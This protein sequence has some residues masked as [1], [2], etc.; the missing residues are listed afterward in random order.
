MATAYCE[1]MCSCA[2]NLTAHI[3]RWLIHF[4]YFTK[5]WW[6]L[7]LPTSKFNIIICLAKSFQSH[8]GILQTCCNILHICRMC[9]V[10]ASVP[11]VSVMS[12]WAPEHRSSYH[13]LYNYIYMLIKLG[14]C[15]GNVTN[16]PLIKLVV[17]DITAAMWKGNLAFPNN[18]CALLGRHYSVP[19]LHL[20]VCGMQNNAW[21]PI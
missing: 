14:V 20:N 5:T 2:H 1:Y 7:L 12:V 3:H 18:S 11:I 4:L 9:H 8:G 13:L 10:T 16:L 19:K 17:C 21:A 15:G 6:R